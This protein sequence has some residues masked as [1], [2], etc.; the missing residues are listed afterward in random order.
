MHGR[1][2][3]DVVRALKAPDRVVILN[4]PRAGGRTGYF[5]NVGLDDKGGGSADLGNFDA[6]EVFSGKDTTRVEPALRD[7]LSLLDRGLQLTAVGGSD[8][9]LVA[10]QEVGWP[11]TCI[12]R[13][14][15]RAARRRG[16][17][18]GAQEAAR[19]AGDQRAVRASVGGRPR[20][21]AAGAGAARARRLDI[22]V[23]AAPW[24]DVRRLELF[25]N[26]SRRGKPID[27][28]PSTK[29][30]RYK[31]SIDLRLERD[32]YVVVVVRGDALGAVLAG[33]VDRRV[34]ADGAGD[35]QPDLFRSRRRRALDAAEREGA[36]PEVGGQ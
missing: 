15:G 17:G 26:G 6:V 36:E 4:H 34:A 29:V 9:H 3:A 31:A 23:E 30:Q 14:R 33:D 24:V 10:G 12:R 19:G 1:A 5:E 11:R 32:A 22:E 21:G 18:R 7:W 27:V 13:R 20:H 16:A 35:H 2:A 25:I 28:P 8:S